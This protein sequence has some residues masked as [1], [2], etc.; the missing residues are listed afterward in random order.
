MAGIIKLVLWI[1]LC[2]MPDKLS[3]SAFKGT[4]K[5]SVPDSGLSSSSPDIWLLG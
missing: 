5:A 1:V 4:C 3:L 2:F